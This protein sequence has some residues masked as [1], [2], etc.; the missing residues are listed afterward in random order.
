M[1]K[2]ESYEVINKKY[3]A[4]NAHHHDL[5]NTQIKLDEKYF[6][7]SQ[8]KQINQLGFDVIGDNSNE[9]PN[10]P[11]LESS[12]INIK[13][14]YTQLYLSHLEIFLST[15]AKL[16]FISKK[17]PEISIILIL[18]NRAE[19]TY[20]CLKSLIELQSTQNV[21]F[22]IIIVDNASSDKTPDLLEKLEGV[23]IIKNSCNFNY[24]LAV[25][26]GA[27]AANGKFLLLLNNDAQVLP[28]SL[29]SAI[30]TI[31]SEEDIGAVGG[32]II[33]LDGTLQEAGSII[34]QDASCAGYGRGDSPFAPEYMFQRDVDYSSGAFLLTPKDLFFK[35]G[36]FDQSYYPAY[37]EET[38]YCFRLKQ[39]GKRVVYDPNAVILH[40]EFASSQSSKQAIR[41][42]IKNQENFL[43][44]HSSFLKFQQASVDLNFLEARMLNQ[45]RRILFIDDRVPHPSLGSGFP[46]ANE[47]ILSLIDLGYFITFY[48]LNFPYESWSSAYDDIPNTVEIMLNYG[49]RRLEEFLQQRQDYYDILLVSRHH[50]MQIVKSIIQHYPSW[51][52]NIKIVYDAEALFSLRDIEKSKLRGITMAKVETDKLVNNEL[53]LTQ[54]TDKIICVS[55]REKEI[56]NQYS[57][58]SAYVLGH[59]SKMSPTSLKFEDRLN[60]LFVGPLAN[61]DTPNTDSIFW[62]ITEILPKIRNEQKCQNV[63]LHL[64]GDFQSEMIKKVIDENIK[65]IGKVEDLTSYYNQARIFIAPTRFSAGIPLKIHGAASHGLPV[66]C[67][68]LLSRQLGWQDGLELLVGDDPSEYARKCIELYT[69]QSLWSQIRENALIRVNRDCSSENF[70]HQLKIIFDDL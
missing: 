68:S 57:Y 64:V 30:K 48:P 18:Y 9:I 49:I 27:M 11:F 6:Q 35:L 42:Q 19:L 24:L 63:E 66:V 1:T 34:W 7:K 43:Q 69:N 12:G 70:R 4:I 17:T 22:E 37:Y 41:L 8:S 54:G 67:T 15:N 44:K 28:G 14:I 33:L 61:Y 38:D 55:N 5:L 13:Q 47:I 51:F 20:Q 58:N 31:K 10:I 65:I 53:K 26:Q 45:K 56:L 59:S 29:I 52:T 60:I 32:K 23:K 50:N 2:Q 3:Q 25:N 36:G 21:S 16:C 46:R 40:F 62:F 39:I